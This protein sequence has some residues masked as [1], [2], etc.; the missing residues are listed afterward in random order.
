[1]IRRVLVTGA[2][3][4]LGRKA[5]AA[6]LEL[7]EVAVIAVDDQPAHD[8]GRDVECIQA[9]LSAYDSIWAGRFADVDV[10]LHLAADPRPVASWQSVL[11]S[12]VDLSLNALRAAEEQGVERFVFA[13]SNWV[14]GG[15]RFSKQQLTPST[16]PRPV[17]PY[18]FSKLITERVGALVAARSEMAFLALR[19][20][21]CQPGENRPG[22]HMAFGRWGQELWL[23]NDDWRQVVQRACT[24][25]FAGFNVVNVMSDNT[26][27]RW[28]LSE[29]ERLLGYRPRSRHTP[30]LT[31]RRRISDVAARVRDTLL[32][33]IASAHRF[34]ARW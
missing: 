20:G 9:D 17:N 11:R 22:P 3:G 30:R 4:N 18:G 6:L 26:G 34:G 8:L 13:S 21:W 25:A 32:A 16:P 12:N 7:D 24:T 27:M 15:L 29:T 33:P 2:A 19:I 10:V 28:D 14:L 1:M 31:V 5:I 23:S